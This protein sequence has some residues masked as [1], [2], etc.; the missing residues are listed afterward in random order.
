ML[1]RPATLRELGLITG[2]GLEELAPILSAIVAI[3]VVTEKERGRDVTYEI[4]HPLVRDL[5]YQA[6]GGARRRLLHRDVAAALY[7]HGRTGEAA[8][9]FA[10]CA[11]VGDA[12]VIDALRDAVRQ[13]EGREA[14]R[15]AL[16]LLGELG[17]LLPSG[18]PRWLDV[19][20]A[21]WWVARCRGRRRPRLVT[22]LTAASGPGRGRGASTPRGRRAGGPAAPADQCRSPPPP[23][24]RSRSPAPDRQVPPPIPP[25][26]RRSR[27]PAR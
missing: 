6:I 22:A 4:H 2:R 13:A 27:A 23:G 8:R 24:P 15:E 10:R 1:G 19:S 20:E 14:Y 3:R 18:D 21:M 11:D 16:E 7:R 26:G 17:E 12:D 9:H 25:R 5:I